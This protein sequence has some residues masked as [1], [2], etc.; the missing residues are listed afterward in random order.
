MLNRRNKV[1]SPSGYEYGPINSLVGKGE[2]IINFNNQTASYVKTGKVGKDTE[3]SSVRDDDD[4]VI[5]GNDIN[6]KTGNKFSQEALP[7]TMQ[8][9]QINDMEKKL[10]KK[11]SKYD[12]LYKQTSKINNSQFAMAKQAPMQ[13]LSMLADQQKAQHDLEGRHALQR[14]NIGDDVPYLKWRTNPELPLWNNMFRQTDLK[15]VPI[16]PFADQNID[17]QEEIVPVRDVKQT[18]NIENQSAPNLKNKTPKYNSNDVSNIPFWQRALPHVLGLGAALNKYGHWKSNPVTYHSTYAANPYL[19]RALSIMAQNRIS[20]YFAIKEALDAERRAAYRLNQSGGLTGGQKQKERVA[21]ALGSG[22]NIANILN[23]VNEKNAAL[24]NQY[25]EAAAKYGESTASRMQNAN[26]FDWNDFVA[27]HGRKTKGIEQSLA[28]IVNQAKDW[29]S[30]D[31]KYN[32]WKDTT[33][34]YKQALDQEQQDWIRKY[35]NA[36]ANNK[37]T[38]TT[39]VVTTST[40]FNSRFVFTKPNFTPNLSLNTFNYTNPL[41]LGYYSKHNRGKNRRCK[42]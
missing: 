39:P 28:D 11:N 20:P 23:T 37:I 5:L 2:S 34:M 21:M 12:S 29:Y 31:F 24:R 10:N 36:A 38:T 15:P 42:R 18:N 17:D 30:N 25:V 14:F 27:A 8:I 19:N 16:I 35:N 1:W 32:A 3:P 26:Q 6:W 22:Q 40:P 13:A 7:H 41:S 33:R 4:N 9:E